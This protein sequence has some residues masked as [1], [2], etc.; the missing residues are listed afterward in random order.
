[1][2]NQFE[3]RSWDDWETGG[4]R[5]LIGKQGGRG[6]IIYNFFTGQFIELGISAGVPEEFMI[7]LTFQVA[8]QLQHALAE[9]LEAQGARTD[10]KVR[11]EASVQGTL[12]ATKYHLE[13]LRKLLKLK[14]GNEY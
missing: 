3:I 6:K 12:Q 13:D 9:W 14:A 11:M 4:I 2:G 1:M 5:F 10:G 7:T 8:R